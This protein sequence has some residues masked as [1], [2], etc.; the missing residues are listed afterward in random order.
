MCTSVC[1][2]RCDLFLYILRQPG[3][4]HICMVV[5]RGRPLA[6]LSDVVVMPSAPDDCEDS[7]SATI[8]GERSDED[9]AVNLDGDVCS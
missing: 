8:A 5:D 1:D 9:G 6:G 3:N 7:S 2:F 4:P